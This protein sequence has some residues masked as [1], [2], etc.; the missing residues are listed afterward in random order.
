MNRQT[1][2]HATLADK[3]NED[4][5]RVNWHDQTLWWVRAKRDRIAWT[6]PEW[7][8]LRDT[9]SSIKLNALGNLHDYLLQFEQQAQQNGAIVHWAADA[10]EHNRIVTEILQK[11]GV[12][13]MVKSKSMLT[14]E[15][16]LNP[17]LEANGIEVIDTDLGERIVQLAK[18][19]PS[20]IVLPCI[21]KK[22]EEIG[23]LFH[24]HLGT[25]AGNA[26][27]QFL[28]AAARLHLRKEFLLADAAITG[29]NF[30]VAETG[31]MVVCTN[32]GNADMG[33]H[34]ANVHIACMGI[35]KIIPQRKH[36]GVFLRLLARSATGQPITTYSSHFRKPRE[37]QELHIVL[38]DNGRSRQ[39]GREDFRNSL[40]CIRCGACMN[41][42]PVYRRSGGHSYH[43]AVAGPIG[44][45]LAPNLDMKDYADLPFASTLCGSCSNV[46]PVKIDIHQQL[47][48]WRQVLV[49]EGY[50]STAKTA[51][52]KVM[53]GVLSAPGVYKAAGKMGRWVMRAFP[54]MVNNRMNPWYK[55][56]EMPVPPA[57]S[58]S[59]WYKKNKKST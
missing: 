37:G 50:T 49:K 19:P 47:Y 43:N 24:E 1:A 40:K 21:H 14:E 41:T 55:Q 53:T 13:R 18:E 57:Q 35:E 30:A 12:K 44:A 31:E 39:L 58:F 54:G 20:H 26:D 16:H 9:A 32:E 10:A 27:P 42:C 51:G 8:Q 6:I 45:I 29:V 56:R 46:C 15:C 11:H 7:E 2:D 48:K 59:E 28:T 23:E 4:E 17:H 25:P 34:L 38:V 3:F 33:A 22:K 36:L 5:P 52:M